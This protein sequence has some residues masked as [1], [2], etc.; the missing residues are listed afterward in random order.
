M[1]ISITSA[2]GVTLGNSDHEIRLQVQDRVQVWLSK[3]AEFSEVSF[4]PVAD[5]QVAMQTVLVW[6]VTVFK[7]LQPGIEKS[8]SYSIAYL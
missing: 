5:Q 7:S 3:T 1:V 4:L 8:Y 6:Q 2:G